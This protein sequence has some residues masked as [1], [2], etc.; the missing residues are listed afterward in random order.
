MLACAVTLGACASGGEQA[1]LV[2]ADCP[3][4]VCDEDGTCAAGAPDGGGAGIDA[5]PGDGDGGPIGCTAN[6][7]GVIERSEVPIGPG[8]TARFRVALDTPVDTAGEFQTG[9]SRT[10]DLSGAMSGDHDVPITLEPL[11]G[12]WFE[13]EFAGASY[14]APLSDT[15]EL[16][17]VFEITSDALMLRGVVSPEAGPTR[18]ELSYDPPVAVTEFPIRAGATWSTTSTITGVTSGVP[19]AYTERYEQMVDAVGELTTP[20]GTFD[21]LRTRVELTRT[22]GAAITTSRSY[23]FSSECY[24]TVASI[25]SNDYETELEFEQAREV[26]R[27]TP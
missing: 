4:G 13:D 7:D 8:L 22:V 23:L 14:S 9:G 12:A 27:L 17:G 6:L 11:A 5:D 18:T 21:V 25:A 19:S 3:S 1:C 26:R 16:L 20:F 10:W 15:Q 24:G 2:G